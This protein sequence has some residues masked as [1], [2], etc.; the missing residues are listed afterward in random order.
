MLLNKLF[1]CFSI[2]LFELFAS[3]NSLF[4]KQEWR[5]ISLYLYV[6]R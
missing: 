5:F 3:T 2:I 4:C 1:K 6:I